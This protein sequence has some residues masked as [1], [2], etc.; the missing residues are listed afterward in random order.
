MSLR[1]GFGNLLNVGIHILP[2]IT[3]KELQLRIIPQRIFSAQ[4]ARNYSDRFSI[5][6]K[7]K[8]IRSV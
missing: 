1:S 2:S 7:K 3:S 6:P 8:K 4:I 5:V